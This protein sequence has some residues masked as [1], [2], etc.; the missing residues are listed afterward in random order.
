MDSI[1]T[2][3]PAARMLDETEVEHFHEVIVGTEAADHDVRGL[4]VAVDQTTSMRLSERV[5]DL[6]QQVHRPRR[7]QP[8][9]IPARVAR[10]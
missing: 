2:V 8:V 5:T 3:W 7:C 1:E 6:A 9:R 4:D 10:D